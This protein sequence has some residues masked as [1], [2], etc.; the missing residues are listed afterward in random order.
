MSTTVLWCFFAD[1][2]SMFEEVEKQEG[3]LTIGLVGE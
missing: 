1:D 3:I 2:G